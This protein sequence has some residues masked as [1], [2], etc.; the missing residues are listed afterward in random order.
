MFPARLAGQRT[1]G[2]EL[3]R[4]RSMT[5]RAA[6]ARNW[7]PLQLKIKKIVPANLVVRQAL[8]CSPLFRACAGH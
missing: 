7:S 5:G 3:G 4:P 6:T 2:A 1:D 8:A